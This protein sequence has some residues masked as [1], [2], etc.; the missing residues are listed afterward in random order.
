MPEQMC[1]SRI[2]IVRLLLAALG[3]TRDVEEF[4]GYYDR[5][6]EGVRLSIPN[7]ADLCLISCL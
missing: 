5:R 3:C 6:E 4:W 2:A 7:G 1:L